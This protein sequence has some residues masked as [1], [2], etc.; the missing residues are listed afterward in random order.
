MVKAMGKWDLP[1]VIALSVP[2][3]ISFFEALSGRLTQPPA[4]RRLRIG[5]L[6]DL[7]AGSDPKVA[8]RCEEA[9]ACLGGGFKL[10]P[11]EL[12]WDAKGFRADPALRIRGALGERTV[13]SRSATRSSRWRW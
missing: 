2:G 4:N 11:V 7:L 10:E 13:A 6:S 3:S 12:G 1:G 9:A 8:A 5:L